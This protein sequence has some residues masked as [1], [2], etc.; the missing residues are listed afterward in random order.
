MTEMIKKLAERYQAALHAVQ[1]GV[2][3][4]IGLDNKDTGLNWD[5][6]GQLQGSAGAKHLRTGL[7]AAMCDH[8]ALVDLLIKK[9]LI[10]DEE[11]VR[12]IT[13]KLEEEVHIHEAEIEERLKGPDGKGPKITLK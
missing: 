11:Y 7:N 3:I 9:G 5:S 1:S 6:P 2:A 12:A 4:V 10:T 13:I 8:G